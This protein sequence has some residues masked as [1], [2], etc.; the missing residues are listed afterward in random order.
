MSVDTL[1]GHSS[2]PTCILG[3]PP[4]RDVMAL[5]YIFSTLAGG[6]FVPKS[7]GD[8]PNFFEQLNT[9]DKETSFLDLNIKVIASD[10][11]TSVYDKRDDFGF[12]LL[13]SHG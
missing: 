9:S 2:V 8:Y 7:S 13:I 11:Y 6:Q 3:N 1:D 10:I 12:L 5:T 4:S